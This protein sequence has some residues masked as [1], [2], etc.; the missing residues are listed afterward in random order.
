MNLVQ[1]KIRWGNILNFIEFLKTYENAKKRYK[2]LEHWRTC[3]EEERTNCICCGKDLCTW[4]SLGG[5]FHKEDTKF[6]SLECK[7]KYEKEHK[8]HEN[9]IFQQTVLFSKNSFQNFI[10]ERSVWRVFFNHY[11]HTKIQK[12][13]DEISNIEKHMLHM[14]LLQ[15]E[16]A[17]FYSCRVCGQELCLW[18]TVNCP[19]EPTNRCKN[20]EEILCEGCMCPHCCGCRECC[21]CDSCSCDFEESTK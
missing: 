3:L 8:L 17:M 11:V 2:K 5:A 20:S 15:R 21:S 6:C 12:L 4:C 16:E 13:Q 19:D 14:P 9:K 7:Q 1:E 10:D 18:C